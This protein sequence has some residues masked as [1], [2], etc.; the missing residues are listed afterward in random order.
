MGLSRIVW[1]K[2]PVE[3][4]KRL[5]SNSIASLSVSGFMAKLQ[6]DGKL[7]STGEDFP[8]E[9]K[10]F[11]LFFQILVVAC[12]LGIAHHD[13]DA[14]EAKLKNGVATISHCRNMLA[15]AEKREQLLIAMIP[16]M[17]LDKETSVVCGKKAQ[18]VYNDL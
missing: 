9:I 10:D 18:D 6:D 16:C 3:T 17:K 11:K 2:T 15:G 14:L 5:L 7:Q 12:K 8:K 13:V 1:N 4:Y